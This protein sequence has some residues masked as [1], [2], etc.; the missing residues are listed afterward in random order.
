MVG[1]QAGHRAGLR[2]G[3]EAQRRPADGL[4]LRQH[5]LP[6]QERPGDQ[7]WA[8]L[9]PDQL[10]VAGEGRPHAG[11]HPGEAGRLLSSAG[12]HLDADA[13]AAGCASRRA[14]TSGPS[15]SNIITNGVVQAQGVAARYADRARAQRRLLGHEADRCSGRSTGSSR[16]AAATRCWP[17]TRPASSTRSAPAPH[18]SCR[19]T[20][21]TGSMADPKLKSELMSF[22]QSATMFISR[23]HAPAPPEGSPGA[24][25]AR[26]GAGATNDHR[27][28]AEAT[29]T[30][31][32]T[33]SSQ[34][35]SSA[36]SRTSGRRTTSRAAKNC[37]PTPATPTARGF[38]EITF[39]Y[40]TSDQWKPLGEYLQQRWKETLGSTSS[41]TRWSWRSS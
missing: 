18:S 5:A 13:A 6:D 1:R 9:D 16:R 22:D 10:G 31:P 38:P 3:L 33:P 35:A 12:Q 40:N 39:T 11:R 34:K 26:P 32:P 27:R 15:R 25:G 8:Q 41:S 36:G 2:L 23:Q 28:G 21:S 14:A 20:R 37:W 17:P 7:R 29:P 4:A 24:D 19:R 30:S